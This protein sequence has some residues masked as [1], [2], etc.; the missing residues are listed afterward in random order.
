[1]REVGKRAGDLGTRRFG[2]SDVAS[3]KVQLLQDRRQGLCFRA[4]VALGSPVTVACEVAIVAD[5]YGG[6]LETLLST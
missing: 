4:C 3:S 1:M 5:A 2:F 6:C